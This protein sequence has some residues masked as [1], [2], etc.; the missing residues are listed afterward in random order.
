MKPRK[1]LIDTYQDLYSFVTS[2]NYKKI[3]VSGP[4]RSGTTFLSQIL[5]ND[6]GWGFFDEVD[7]I[8]RLYTIRENTIIQGPLIC[9]YLHL[10]DLPNTLVI[11][12]ARNGKDIGISSRNTHLP[13]GITI[14]EGSIAEMK[15]C[16][17]TFPEFYDSA[18]DSQYLKQN[19]WLSFQMFNMKIDSLT[20]PY[21]GLMTDPRFLDKTQRSQFYFKQTSPAVIQF[22]SKPTQFKYVKDPDKHGK[23]LENRK[24]KFS[25]TDSTYIQI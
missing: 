20:I 22:E 3:I 5:A 2:K 4:H 18:I 1:E 11:Y 24:Y 23:D 12:L 16:E 8:D 13:G 15:L 25:L 17:K 21:T 10:I 19:I 9:F 7:N 6:L 14:Q